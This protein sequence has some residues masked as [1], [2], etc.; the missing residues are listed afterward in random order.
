MLWHLIHRHEI[1]NAFDALG[2]DFEEKSKNLN[3]E[4]ELLEK[5]VQIQELELLKA[6][7]D[8]V[9]EQTE[10]ALESAEVIKLNKDMQVLATALV[11]RDSILKEKLNIELPDPFK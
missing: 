6:Q 9:K 1:P 11:I 10:K 5:K 7:I 3:Q 4:K 2:K 8:L